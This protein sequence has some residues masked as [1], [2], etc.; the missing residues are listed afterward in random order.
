M[1]YLT[2][3]EWIIWPN[4]K[5]S[6]NI[7]TMIAAFCMNIKVFNWINRK[8]FN[9]LKTFLEHLEFYIVAYWRWFSPRSCL[10][11]YVSV[12]DTGDS[13]LMSGPNVQLLKECI[14]Q[15]LKIDDKGSEQLFFWLTIGLLNTGNTNFPLSL[16]R[17]TGFR[18]KK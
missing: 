3:G 8:Q 18:R 1:L 11:N 5:M 13:F 16:I 14:S 10:K 6:Q 4:I 17:N 15:S 12:D 9:I 7:M 2:W